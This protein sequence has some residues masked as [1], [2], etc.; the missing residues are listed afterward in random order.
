MPYLTILKVTTNL[1]NP[2]VQVSSHSRNHQLP[3]DSFPLSVKIGFGY[4]LF[5][6]KMEMFLAAGCGSKS[7]FFLPTFFS[8]PFLHP[9]RHV[10]FLGDVVSWYQLCLK[11]KPRIQL[12]SHRE[13]PNLPVAMS[14][15]AADHH[16]NIINGI[17]N[18]DY[19]I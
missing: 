9:F 2:C 14:V 19:S 12:L 17:H 6:I 13:D 11:Q 16:S 3:F 15:M 4:I 7:S 1:S 18:K 5:R 10:L 8:P